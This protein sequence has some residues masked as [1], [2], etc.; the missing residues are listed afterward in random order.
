MFLS[1]DQKTNFAPDDKSATQIKGP[2]I[3]RFQV[4]FGNKAHL[5]IRSQAI[6]VATLDQSTLESG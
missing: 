6:C 5:I 2:I 1:I 3:Y 4:P